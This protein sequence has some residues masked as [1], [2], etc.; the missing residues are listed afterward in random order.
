MVT[1]AESEPVPTARFRWPVLPFR[2]EGVLVALVVVATYFV[3]SVADV[4][5][6]GVLSDDAVYTVLGK[7]LAEGLGYHSIHLVGAPIQVKYPPGFPFILSLLWRIG[8]S[9]EAVQRLI[10]F[11]HPVVIG[12]AAGLVWW[13]GR[14]RL[15]APA[16][17]LAFLALLPLVLGASIEY[18]TL[19]LSEPWFILGWAGVLVLWLNAV[20]CPPGRARLLL[21][22]AAGALIAATTLVRTQ[23]IVLLPAVAV[24]MLP[25][26]H[27]LVERLVVASTILLP[28]GAWHFYH[29]ALVA[30]GPVSRL[31]DEGPYIEWIQGAGATVRALV[32]GVGSNV[33]F[34]LTQLGD[35]LSGISTFGKVEAALI[36][37]GSV[38]GAGFVARRQPVLAVSVLGS[39]AIVL[40]WPFAQDRLLLPLLPFMGLGICAALSPFYMRSAPR[41]RRGVS[42]VAVGLVVI[43]LVRQ[44]A[45]RK[46]GVAAM[47]ANRKPEFFTPSWLLLLNTR[48]IAAASNWVRTNTAPTAHVMIDKH[49]GIY[50]YSGRATVPVNVSESRL[51]PSV[52]ATPG[53]YLATRILEDSVDYLIIGLREPGIMG[54]LETVKL[55]CPGV[56]TWGGT[57]P[58]DSKF[59]FKVRR[60]EACLRG[61]AGR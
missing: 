33:A 35:Y 1:P 41:A 38:V 34:Y 24:A 55:K 40:A 21:L 4:Y 2:A 58:Q 53:L 15:A 59:I 20:E 39:L 27:S 44:P 37:G 43:A 18:F 36:L 50:L 32:A 22:A 7:A 5:R 51:V 25:K 28:L 12:V 30:G 9:V 61:L 47:A 26:R 19:N 13:V 48:Y 42:L 49:A 57:S 60:D 29:S 8:G 52:F 45:V 16:A 11:L 14:A 54:D 3:V 56:L 23:A 10:Y 31:P 17:P 46:E 6:V